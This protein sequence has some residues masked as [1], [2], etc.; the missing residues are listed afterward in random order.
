MPFMLGPQWE[1]D[2]LFCIFEE[3]FRF[4]P[5]SLDE[6]PRCIRGSALQEVVGVPHVGAGT[7]GSAA[8][9]N[10]KEPDSCFTLSA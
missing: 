8:S 9:K 7:A 2:T 5:E 6:E 10:L 3:D 1:E 4:E